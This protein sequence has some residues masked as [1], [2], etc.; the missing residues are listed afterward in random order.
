MSSFLDSNLLKSSII[1]SLS[2]DY[3]E[4]GSHMWGS[5]SDWDIYYI[6]SIPGVSKA[7]AHSALG[8][9]LGIILEELSPKDRD[10][11][12]AVDL[13]RSL[14]NCK[15]DQV[16]IEL[17]QE[18]SVKLGKLAVENRVHKCEILMTGICAVTRAV[19]NEFTSLK[20]KSDK[21]HSPDN[22]ND[23]TSEK[24]A[25]VE[26]ENQETIDYG[27]NLSDNSNE[28]RISQS[29]AEDN[30]AKKLN[31]QSE[32][33]CKKS[34]EETSPA[35]FDLNKFRKELIEDLSASFRSELQNIKMEVEKIKS[36]V[37][38]S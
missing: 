8:I 26:D 30:L 19:T 21:P 12:K 4:R 10:Y 31:N 28:Q 6:N 29:S 14:K 33:L 36:H 11:Y 15:S 16:N 25:R 22:D 34:T 17:W 23:E 5:V 13:K 35:D 3:W 24:K 7:Q 20:R 9:E 18:H 27:N 2:I 38:I 1:Q 32:N 37:K